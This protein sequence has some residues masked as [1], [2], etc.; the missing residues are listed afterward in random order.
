MLT[1]A[2]A[3]TQLSSSDP[4]STLNLSNQSI[5]AAGAATLAEAL[6]VR[7]ATMSYYVF[8]VSVSER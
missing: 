4:P 1:L 8:E 2:Q 3:L 5:D 6:K 7:Y